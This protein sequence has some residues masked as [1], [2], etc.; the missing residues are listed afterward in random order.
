MGIKS[1]ITGTWYIKPYGEAT[2]E[3]MSELNQTIQKY[4]VKQVGSIALTAL[5]IGVIAGSF[6][7]PG[8]LSTV[9]MISGVTLLGPSGASS[10]Y[11]S[12]KKSGKQDK[13]RLIDEAKDN[14]AYLNGLT[15]DCRRKSGKY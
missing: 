10:V 12:A 4:K 8:A 15:I 5:A 9:A 13:K 3:E 1:G 7:I 14:Q 6:F 11:F 2:P